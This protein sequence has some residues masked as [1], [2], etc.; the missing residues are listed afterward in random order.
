MDA[1][2]CMGYKAMRFWRRLGLSVIRITGMA[3][4]GAVSA[5]VVGRNK[6]RPV[7]YRLYLDVLGQSRAPAFYQRYRVA[8]TLDGR[9]EMLLVHVFLLLDRLQQVDAQGQ[10]AS[11]GKALAGHVAD[12]LINDLDQ[13]LREMGVGD[14][15]VGKRIRKMV[16]AYH[17]R[18]AAY[19]QASEQQELQAALHRNVYESR[20][21]EDGAVLAEYMCGAA[22]CLGA[23][24]DATLMHGAALTWPDP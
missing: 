14:M 13:S 1:T 4:A 11:Q 19:G 6:L 16:E 12:W 10:A 17:G 20:S 9:F 3:S 24:S 8:D 18:L 23:M 15:G 21:D 22:N 7:A 5:G 2:A